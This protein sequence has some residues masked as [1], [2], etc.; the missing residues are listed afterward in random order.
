MVEQPKLNLCIILKVQY[1]I[2]LQWHPSHPISQLST[3]TLCLQSDNVI[4]ERIIS[5]SI[6]GLP[7]VKCITVIARKWE[8]FLQAQREIRLQYVLRKWLN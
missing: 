4:D 8:T 5:V 2:L 7:G 3:K 1:G 6:R